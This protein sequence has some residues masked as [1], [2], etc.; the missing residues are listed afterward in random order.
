VP[1]T[2]VFIDL[3]GFTALTEAHGDEEAVIQ[4]DALRECVEESLEAGSRLVKTMGDGA[5]IVGQGIVRTVLA[6]GRLSEVV[7]Q[8]VALPMRCGLVH[9]PVVE[10]KDD[11]FGATVNLASRLVG[12][13]GAR[14]VLSTSEVARAAES[15]GVDV[16]ELGW[17]DVRHRAEPVELFEL[18]FGCSPEPLLVDPVCHMPVRETE[19]EGQ[20]VFRGHRYWFCSLGCA[21]RFLAAPHRYAVH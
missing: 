4:A 15:A 14:Q 18:R 12:L 2:V 17:R 16:I 10:R 8:R 7:E 3:A 20:L 11:V 21:E 1:Q 6:V 13:A 9:G 5:L 19:A